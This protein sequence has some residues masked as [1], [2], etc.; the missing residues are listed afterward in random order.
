MSLK[1]LHFI[2]FLRILKKEKKN[3]IFHRPHYR[4]REGVDTH[5]HEHTNL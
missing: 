3:F 5:A 2:F 1:S 4:A